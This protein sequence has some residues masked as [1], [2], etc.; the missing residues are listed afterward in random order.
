MDDPVASPGY[1]DC[2]V[3]T[4]SDQIFADA[5]RWGI[6]MD[7]EAA[8]ESGWRH[9]CE[10][11]P[12]P[13][14]GRKG[15]ERARFMGF[16]SREVHEGMSWSL[17]N[18]ISD[19]S[20]AHLAERL[21]G[22]AGGARYRAFARYFHNR[23]LAY[24]DLFDPDSGFF[25]GRLPDGSLPS[26][27]FDPRIWGGDNVETN[28]WGMSVA[29]PHDGAGL[30]ALYGGPA[31]LRRHLDILFAE[32]ETGDERYSGAYGTVIHEQREARAQRSGQCAISNQ[33][34]HHIPYMYVFSDQPSRAGATTHALARRL[35]AGG[36]IG[37]GFP[38]DE[39]NGEMSAWWIWAALGLYPLELGSGRLLIGCPLLDDVV[40]HRAGA[41]G[42]TAL[43]V[44]CVRSSPDATVLVSAR[45]NGEEL[46]SCWVPVDALTADAL[47]ELHF[48]HEDDTP[49]A[50]GPAMPQAIPSHHDLTRDNGTAAASHDD[51]EAAALFD[52]LG[53]SAVTLEAGQWVE[54]RFDA[55]RTITD[56]T[57]TAH[58]AT[59]SQDLSFEV[60]LDGATF[61]RAQT[62]HA[63]ELAPN[64]TTPFELAAPVEARAVRLTAEHR[65]VLRQLEFFALSHE[66]GNRHDP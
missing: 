40:V 59:P 18:A 10:P 30:A 41:A 39:D 35:F 52:D 44:R 60:S 45:L 36:M 24:R 48:A 12:S 33:P 57:V 21:A 64:R 49:S 62:T 22:G 53:N 3:G 8:F 58:L 26:E 15:I 37:Q 46:P 54:W 5:E 25:R 63:E 56:L 32:P 6:E 7:A 50:L 17:E 19:A 55:S 61:T 28:A 31:G 65:V 34:A 2:M 14:R 43:R 9:A 38:G 29:A 66:E 4:S 11:A 27:P 13:D 16:V 23:A 51:V 20:L 47:L 1:T 42:R